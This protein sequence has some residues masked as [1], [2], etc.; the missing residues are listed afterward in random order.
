MTTRFTYISRGEVSTRPDGFD[1]ELN[2]LALGRHHSDS[3]AFGYCEDI[4]GYCEVDNC[5]L[6]SHIVWSTTSGIA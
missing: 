1:A 2:E 5:K 6:Q 3:L 4:A